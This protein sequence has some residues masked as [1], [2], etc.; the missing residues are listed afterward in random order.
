VCR[1]PE[2]I[3][4]R[5]PRVTQLGELLAET[6]RMR[7]QWS[8]HPDTEQVR[9]VIAS[10]SWNKTWSKKHRSH[11]DPADVAAEHRVLVPEH[12]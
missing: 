2:L 4:C 7:L 10:Y 8:G 9:L 12:Q 5:Q 3:G 6:S 1:Q 11:T